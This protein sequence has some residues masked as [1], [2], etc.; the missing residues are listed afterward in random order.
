MPYHVSRERFAQLV[1]RALAA[2]PP[3]FAR[4]LEDEVRIEIRDRPTR[5]ELRSLGLDDDE[6]LLG[7]YQ[8]HPLTE[9]SVESSGCLPD[10]IYVFQEDC[11]LVSD[12]EQQLIEEVRVTVLHEL[13]HHFGLGEDELER[14][15]YR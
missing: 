2:L 11:E 5:R 6:L 1:E 15:G 12:S 13:G 7:L 9:R 4:A 14:L 8:G 10:V 3:E